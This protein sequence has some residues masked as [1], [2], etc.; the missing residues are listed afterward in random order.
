[1]IYLYIWGSMPS[2]HYERS[3]LL[4]YLWWG[5]CRRLSVY[6]IFHALIWF[7]KDSSLSIYKVWTPINCPWWCSGLGTDFAEIFDENGSLLSAG[8]VSIWTLSNIWTK[9]INWWNQIWKNVKL[10]QLSIHSSDVL[11]A[12]KVDIKRI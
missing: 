9:M 5:R 3:S 12:I 6:V 7:L 2:Q 8:L 1:M 11:I 10:I 4:T